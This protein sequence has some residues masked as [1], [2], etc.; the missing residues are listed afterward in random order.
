MRL[1]YGWGRGERGCWGGWGGSIWAFSTEN[2]LSV[3][4][5]AKSE[6]RHTWFFFSLLLHLLHHFIIIFLVFCLMLR[7]GSEGDISSPSG[8]TLTQR[9]YNYLLSV[10]FAHEWASMLA[11]SLSNCLR[12]SVATL[13]DCSPIACCM[14]AKKNGR[15]V[16]I[17]YLM[18]GFYPPV[19][20][21]W[22]CIVD[23]TI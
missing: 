20:T 19:L 12:P 7:S 18:W 23:T 16:S 6:G 2:T 10:V 11:L 17:L 4:T 3:D 9:I 1:I 21:L 22:T 8:G 5:A 13:C 15:I 14:Y